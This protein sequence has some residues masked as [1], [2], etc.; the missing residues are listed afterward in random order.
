MDR[1]EVQGFHAVAWRRRRS[2]CCVGLEH[3][4]ADDSQVP[5]ALGYEKCMGI[6]KRQAPRMKQSRGN[7]HYTDFAIF[8]IEDLLRPAWRVMNQQS[9][10]QRAKAPRLWTGF[11]PTHT[12]GTPPE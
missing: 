12:I 8:R 10:K 1:Y 11:H 9:K 3:A 6:G 2:P 5:V 7:R 4:I